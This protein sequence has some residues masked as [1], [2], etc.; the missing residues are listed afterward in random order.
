MSEVRG[1]LLSL[2]LPSKI[3]SSSLEQQPYSTVEVKRM[4]G[5]SSFWSNLRNNLGNIWQ[6]VKDSG[7][8]NHLG[9][10]AKTMLASSGNPYG[11]AGTAAMGALGFG[12]PGHRVISD[13]VA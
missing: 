5:G 12:R 13:R 3:C 2:Y 10:A 11:A 4:V 1:P 9:T 7:A 8:L 6:K